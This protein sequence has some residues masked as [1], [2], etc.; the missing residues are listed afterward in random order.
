MA[1]F[2]FTGDQ[3]TVFPA[4]AAADG[5]TLVC[6]PGDSVVLDADPGIDTLQPAGKKDAAAAPEA[7]QTAPEAPASDAPAS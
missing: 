2:T 3:E 6:R 4:L 1:N 7:P 5:S